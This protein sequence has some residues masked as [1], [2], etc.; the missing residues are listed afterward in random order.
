MVVNCE[1][2]VEVSKAILKGIFCTVSP[3]RLSSSSRLGNTIPSLSSSIILWSFFDLR[4][5]K[6]IA[7]WEF[8]VFLFFCCGSNIW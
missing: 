3:R 8:E 1:T 2:Q 6:S 4:G 5:C 7:L